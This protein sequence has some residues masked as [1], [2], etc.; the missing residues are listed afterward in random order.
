MRILMVSPYPPVRDGI[1]AYAVQT[2]AALR[3]E[4]HDVEV[5]SPGPSAAHHHLDLLGPRGALALAKRVRDYDRVIVQFHP[6]FFYRQ[7]ATAKELVSVSAALTA[8]FRASPD[9][10]VRVHEVDYRLGRGRGPVAVAMR[11]MW[12]SVPRVIVHTDAE[13]AAFLEAFAVPP[14]RVQVAAHGEHFSRRTG[15]D[16]VEARRRLGIPVE[17]FMFLSLGF[18]QP[19]KGFDRAIRAFAGLGEH[20]CRLDIVGSIRVEDPAYVEHLQELQRMARATAGVTVHDQYVSDEEFDRWLVAADVVVLPY[21]HIWSSGVIERAALYDRVV[22]ASRVGG[23][24]AQA[25]QGTVLVDDDERLAQAMREAA[26]RSAA[27]PAPTEPWTFDGEP[28][29][30]AVMAEI[31]ARAAAQRGRPVPDDAATPAPRRSANRSSAPL[32]RVPALSL[33]LPA[34]ARFGA[35]VTKRLVRR[36]T[37]WELQPIVEQVNVLQRAAVE[38]AELA[39]REDDE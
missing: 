16:R 19:H 23:L 22:I 25:R 14:E 20:G 36:L 5:L 17:D 12:R 28:D 38:A 3:A 39:A 9:L 4:G 26:G 2:V 32:R 27:A 34:S 37:A 15:L 13:K 10:E 1:A 21:R 35:G 6:D 30:E 7:P 24:D 11:A 29:R 8:A 33:P 31:V 18:I